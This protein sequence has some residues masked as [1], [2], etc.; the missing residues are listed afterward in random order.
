MRTLNGHYEGFL[1]IVCCIFRKWKKKF[2]GEEL[3]LHRSALKQAVTSCS[4]VV[5][6][7][8]LLIKCSHIIAFYTECVNSSLISNKNYDAYY[9]FLINVVEIYLGVK[10]L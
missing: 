3:K 5:G 6:H 7:R 9:F 8:L 4:G 1:L 2:E 10:K